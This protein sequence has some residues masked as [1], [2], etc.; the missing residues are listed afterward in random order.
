MTLKGVQ[1]KEDNFLENF[2]TRDIYSAL[3]RNQTYRYILLNLWCMIKA[4]LNNVPIFYNIKN[5]KKVSF[6]A[7]NNFISLACCWLCR[8]FLALPQGYRR[9]HHIRQWQPYA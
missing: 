1:E 3:R 6:Y 2:Q 4:S 7:S 9:H 8:V 5:G